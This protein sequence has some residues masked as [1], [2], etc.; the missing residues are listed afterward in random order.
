MKRIFSLILVLLMVLST[1]V[2][3]P[4]L[5]NAEEITAQQWR[6][7]PYGESFGAFLSTPAA[8]HDTTTFGTNKTDAYLTTFINNGV[9]F[10]GAKLFN[11]V[12][13]V[14]GVP[15]NGMQ[16]KTFELTETDV[17]Y[18]KEVGTIWRKG[19]ISTVDST[20][21]IGEITLT[22]VNNETDT[23]IGHGY[24]TTGGYN[25]DV[26]GQGT[27]AYADGA[28]Y[29]TR[30]TASGHNNVYLPLTK[31]DARSHNSVLF[32]LIG[33]EYSIDE[34]TTT[35]LPAIINQLTTKKDAGEDVTQ[36]VNA[37]K[38][39]VTSANLRGTGFD[40]VSEL[41]AQYQAK[42]EELS[43][44]GPQEMTG[45]SVQATLTKTL[46][47]Q[48][49]LLLSSILPVTGIENYQ[50]ATVKYYIE[51][52]ETTSVTAEGVYIVK[53]VVS[54]DGYAD[55][56]FVTTLTVV[57]GQ[58]PSESIGTHYASVVPIVKNGRNSAKDGVAT[59]FAGQNIAQFGYVSLNSLWSALDDAST[60]QS[61][62]QNAYKGVLK[63]YDGNKIFY[64]TT[65]VFATLD[66][67]VN[68]QHFDMDIIWNTNKTYNLSGKY[69]KGVSVVA[70]NRYNANEQG[71]QATLISSNTSDTDVVSG[72]LVLKN[73][74]NDTYSANTP[75]FVTGVIT[76]ETGTATTSAYRVGINTVYNSATP[77]PVNQIKI[78]PSVYQCVAGVFA[79]YE[80]EYSVEELEDNIVPSIVNSLYSNKDTMSDADFITCIDALEKTVLSA[81]ER[82]FKLENLSSDVV[83]K[84]NEIVVPLPE[85]DFLAI[86]ASTP[87]NEA[88]NVD[89]TT[90]SIAVEFSNILEPSSVDGKVSVTVNG[91]K[92][93]TSVVAI[94]N[95]VIITLPTAV[96]ANK[97]VVVTFDAGIKDIYENVMV[98]DSVT[99][100]T[101]YKEL[102]MAT[103][104]EDDFETAADLALWTAANSQTS[105]QIVDDPYKV[106]NKV[107]KFKANE[108]GGS[109]A[110]F[111][112]SFTDVQDGAGTIA[113]TFKYAWADDGTNTDWG[114]MPTFMVLKDTNNYTNAY[115][116]V[117]GHGLVRVYGTAKEPGTNAATLDTTLK[118]CQ[119]WQEMTY[120]IDT[121]NSSII[122]SIDGGE[123]VTRYFS[124][125]LAYN[126][127][128]KEI[129][130]Q[131][132]AS[133]NDLGEAEFYLDDVKVERI[134]DM[135]VRCNYSDTLDPSKDIVYTSNLPI[136]SATVSVT[137]KKGE[138]VLSSGVISEDKKTFT[139]PAKE[140]L[141]YNQT[142]TIKYSFKSAYGTI[143]EGSATVATPKAKSV[144][145]IDNITVTPNASKTEFT[146][147]FTI[148]NPE[149]TSKDAWVVIAVYNE[150]NKMLKMKSAE[151]L[152][153]TGEFTPDTPIVVTGVPSGASLIR[154]FMWDTKKDLNAYH[155][156]IEFNIQ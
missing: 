116:S 54:S 48:G 15:F 73:F 55:I 56:E 144:N 7:L 24:T 45:L 10:N 70:N 37:L 75:T 153:P 42:Y 18:Y 8:A 109:T 34:L 92:V 99:F 23:V 88:K 14:H 29:I 85:S 130:I 128:Y 126:N 108:K 5:A 33:V 104:F 107:L 30:S 46:S 4:I 105:L 102:P 156:P 119:K 97:T 57:N 60:I 142:Y 131:L 90:T 67:A 71:Y 44:G 154:A 82:G 16:T 136:S 49:S 35:I 83:T 89:E 141:D 12:N 138:V 87:T 51:E 22:Y 47:E 121:S 52:T 59:T 143:K 133:N 65:D 149:S 127:I 19:N 135:A 123:Y 77:I 120:I 106:S 20:N 11:S 134:P 115:M 9:I 36:E 64:N 68:G 76:D 86:T 26:L 63:T 28:H 98:K 39:T 110:T 66:Q 40:V 6:Q 84:Y 117:G 32:A 145:F 58:S 118:P 31:V 41:S 17:K 3:V 80:I 129:V 125:T 101:E 137:N 69:L 13:P 147:S 139:I 140:I 100:E 114:Y 132:G 38:N 95:K 152:V 91:T 150:N 113:V 93:Q 112:R 53:T 74:G 103:L 78:D 21:H 50:G 122:Y 111:T 43:A 155:L 62:G 124:T 72:K 79:I 146:A 151:Y 81:T 1:V 27:E 94:R 25:P 148:E 96:G 61:F 2:A